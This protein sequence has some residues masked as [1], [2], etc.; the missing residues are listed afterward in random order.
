MRMFINVCGVCAVAL[1][2]LNFQ[3]SFCLCQ[4]FEVAL[5]TGNFMPSRNVVFLGEAK[6]HQLRFISRLVTLWLDRAQR[7][8]RPS[9]V[10]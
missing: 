9:G 5:S 8:D 4:R 2:T 3:G 6:N 7:I 10:K 1:T